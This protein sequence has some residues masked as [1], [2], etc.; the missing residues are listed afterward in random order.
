MFFLV[1][2][3]HNTVGE[4]PRFF[5]YFGIELVFKFV[6]FWKYISI[7]ELDFNLVCF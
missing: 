4:A 2:F 5:G 3:Y 1:F 7:F 6:R